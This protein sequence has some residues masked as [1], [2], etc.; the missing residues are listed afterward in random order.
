M[1][2]ATSR[3]AYVAME[4]TTNRRKNEA[5][6]K[7]GRDESNA[8]PGCGAARRGAAVARRD[9]MGDEDKTTRAHR[10]QP[11]PG[12]RARHEGVN[13]PLSLVG[14]NISPVQQRLTRSMGLG[15]RGCMARVW[16][17]CDGE[18]SAAWSA[19]S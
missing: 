16:S 15:S 10:A 2:I 18:A 13:C 9:G 5:E 3:Y 14:R 1:D 17:S 8:V 12:E 11:R 4:H 6:G 7:N 19:A